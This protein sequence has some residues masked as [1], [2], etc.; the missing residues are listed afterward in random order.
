VK[1]RIAEPGASGGGVVP[2]A[3]D[4]PPSGRWTGAALLALAVSAARTA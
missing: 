1:I 4:S 3:R 2:P